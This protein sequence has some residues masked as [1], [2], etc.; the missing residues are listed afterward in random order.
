[1]YVKKKKQVTDCVI[2]DWCQEDRNFMEDLY[3]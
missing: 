3:L 1:M 2:G